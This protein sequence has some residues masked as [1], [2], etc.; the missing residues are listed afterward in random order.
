MTPGEFLAEH[1]PEVATL[2]EDLRRVVIA[3]MPDAEERVYVGWHGLGYVHPGAGYVCGIFPSATEVRLGFEHGHM[4]PDPDGLLT[5]E[6]SQV[7][8]VVLPTGSTIPGEA[9]ADLIAD[10]VDLRA[11]R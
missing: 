7:R 6:G 4:L 1:T 11:P 9:I 2:I 8:Y 3:A 10:A 5:G